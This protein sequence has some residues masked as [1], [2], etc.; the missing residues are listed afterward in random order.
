M[1]TTTKL[2]FAGSVIVA[3]MLVLSGGCGYKT[4]PVPPQSV[5]PKAITD[6]EYSLDEKGARLTW[7]YPVE[8]IDGRE[9]TAVNGFELYRAEIP[10]DGFC[11]SCPIP[12]GDPI[13]LPG[14]VT[15]MENRQIAQYDSGMLRSGNKYYF[16]VRSTTSWWAASGDSN[17]VGFV[18]HTPAAAPRDLT[19][20]VDGTGVQLSWSPVDSLI[21]GGIV[22]LPVI[23]QV[24]RSSNGG[25]FSEVGG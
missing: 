25:D 10:L 6:L 16:K 12:F 19:A 14:G 4:P 11:S 15:V 24:L 5:V 18:Y 9:L 13:E 2:G 8:T 21:N 22:E 1:K 3:G 23:Y 20:S 7:S 17:I